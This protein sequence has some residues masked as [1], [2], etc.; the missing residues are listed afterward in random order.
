[1]RQSRQDKSR[2]DIGAKAKPRYEWR[3][4][5]IVCYHR[6]L[7]SSVTIIEVKHSLP[8]LRGASIFALGQGEQQAAVTRSHVI[9]S[10]PSSLQKGGRDTLEKLSPSQ[11]LPQGAE[12]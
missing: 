12:R 5:T 7:P 3:V 10:R 11:P 9:V 1:M 2:Q 6:L 4:V 8:Y